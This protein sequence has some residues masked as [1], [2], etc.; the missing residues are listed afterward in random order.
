MSTDD[1]HLSLEQLADALAGG[2]DDAG[3]LPSCGQC[4]Q[5]LQDLR[6]ASARVTGVLAGLPAPALPDDLDRRL[7][8][9]LRAER[10]EA[11]T[12]VTPLSARRVRPARWLPAAAAVVLLLAGAGYGLSRL[13]GGPGS[14][15][16]AAGGGASQSAAGLELA[17]SSTGTDYAGRASLARAL[18]ALLRGGASAPPE[19]AADGATTQSLPGAAPPPAAAKAADP[20]ARLRTDAGLAGCLLALLPPQ[21][22]SVRPL[23]VDYALFRGAPAV[24]VVLPGSVAGKLDVFV[25]GPQCSPANDS[26]LFYTSVDRP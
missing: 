21:D 15:S 20:L 16:P 11:G 23:A 10:A 3:H 24:V 1:G 8:D 14:G 22:P 2:S 7:H 17:R 6:A 25:V 9:S 13:G 19:A 12:G 4:G 18:P 26:V 5:A